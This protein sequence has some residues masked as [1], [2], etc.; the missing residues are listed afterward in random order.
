MI[1]RVLSEMAMSRAGQRSGS[2]DPVLDEDEGSPLGFTDGLLGNSLEE[3]RCRGSVGL[4]FEVAGSGA[5]SVMYKGSRQYTSGPQR[6]EATRE[7]LI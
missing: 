1:A 5:K 7:P 4:D 3:H 2:E 6:A